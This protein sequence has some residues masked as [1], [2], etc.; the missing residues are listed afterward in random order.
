MYRMLIVDDE[1]IM[2]EGLHLM[3]QEA[4]HLEL[5]LHKAYSAEDAMRIMERHRMDIVL[6]DI[7]MPQ[8]NGLTLQQNLQQ[9]WPRCKVI[10]LTGY[11]HSN[12]IHQSIRQGAVDYVLKTEGD[13]VILAAV[14]KA[15]QQL[16]Q[17]LNYDDLAR[18]ARDQMAEAIPSLQKDYWM[19]IL[20]GESSTAQVRARRFSHLNIP[21][22]A[23]HPVLLLVGR[24]DGSRESMESTDKSLLQYCMKN[25]TEEFLQPRVISCY[26]LYD[27]ERMVWFLQPSSD[28]EEAVTLSYVKGLLERIQ[29]ACQSYVKISCSF[30][31]ASRFVKWDEV[32]DTFDRL[33]FTMLQGFGLESGMILSD[34]LVDSEDRLPYECRQQLKKLPALSAALERGEEKAF[35]STLDELFSEMHTTQQGYT[36]EIY[37]S[38][39]AIFI[40]HMNRNRLIFEISEQ[41]N[42]SKWFHLKEMHSWTEMHR[43]FSELALLCFQKKQKEQQHRT[44]EFVEQVQAYI[45]SHLD[46]DLSLTNLSEQVYLTPSYLSRLFRQNTGESITDYITK[47]RLEQAKAMLTQTPEKIH[48]IGMSI[49]FE[50]PPYFTK[51]LKKNVGMT[52]QEYRD[53]YM[54]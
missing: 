39:L 24:M 16:S 32:A 47:M 21:L 2:V 9:K 52:P 40:S 48:K 18:K 4:D 49:G 45:Q 36:L 53:M 34:K 14:E 5:E 33:Q 17:E 37:Y 27:R 3:L 44:H 23:D 41:I 10:F 43:K 28:Q 15:Y 31:L 51:F 30:A 8:C 22:H 1:P 19:D 38:L 6:T 54:K 13:E 50:S 7:E 42:M 46:G 35:K 26:V 11:S 12:Y 29:Q 20:K 25:I